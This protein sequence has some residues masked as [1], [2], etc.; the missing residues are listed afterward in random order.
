MNNEK[1]D[2]LNNTLKCLMPLLKE[3]IE[4]NKGDCSDSDDEKIVKRHKELFKTY[5][6]NALISLEPHVCMVSKGLRACQ[7]WGEE[8][9]MVYV[10]IMD[11]ED[12]KIFSDHMVGV[13]KKI[14]DNKEK[15]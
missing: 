2:N 10:A 8:G 5:L 6:E 11:D 12:F 7:V 1:I 14:I 9:L 4:I 13:D 3:F 15:K